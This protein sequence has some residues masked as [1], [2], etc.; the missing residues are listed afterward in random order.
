MNKDK[1][2]ITVSAY[3][4]NAAGYAKKFM[5]FKSYKEKILLFQERYIKNNSRIL[6]IGCGPGNTAKILHGRN[7]ACKIIGIDLSEQMITFA[8][9]NVPAA[10]FFVGDI[11]KF[12]LKIQFDAIIASFCIVHLSD[13]ETMHLFAKISRLMRPGAYLYLSFMEGKTPGFETTSFSNDE[14]FFNYYDRNA[15]QNCLRR[16]SIEVAEV[17]SDDYPEEDGSITNDIFMFAR[18][19]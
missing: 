18:R 19:R 2:D 5:E 9:N 12:E 16:H 1:T 7:R 6:D 11:R 14:I 15:I 13:E 8:K 3:N 10:D 17:L 4:K